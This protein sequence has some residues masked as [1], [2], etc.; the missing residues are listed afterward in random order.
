MS[1]LKSQEELL[2]ETFSEE[3]EGA[4]EVEQPEET[5]HEEETSEE[6]EG[7]GEEEQ[8]EETEGSS[9]GEEEEEA[10]VSAEEELEGILN[11]SESSEE[12]E[13]G[14]DAGEGSEEEESEEGEEDETSSIELTDDEFDE[15]TTNKEAL[16]SYAEKIQ[17]SALAQAR[18]EFRQELATAKEEILRN[19]PEVVGKV[20]ERA[21]NVRTL[22]QNFFSENPGLKERRGYVKDMTATVSTQNPDWSAKQVLDEV[23]KRA[24]RDLG[25]SVK[26]EKREKER[27]GPKFA[28]AGGRRAP[29]G[30][31]DTRTKQEKLL[32]ETF[33]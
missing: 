15:I 16:K 30:N 7:E 32:D 25:A 4:E 27:K 2:D 6:G 8:E 33:S 31:K 12:E 24:E 23:A 21:Q 26:A 20:S 13:E 17:N 5:E 3:S 19:I 28:G 14:D 29:S 11:P 1:K 10:E 9:G 18:D 22:T